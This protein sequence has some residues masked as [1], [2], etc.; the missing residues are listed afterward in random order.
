MNKNTPEMY[1][2]Q[3]N[4]LKALAHPTRL[5][6]INELANKELCVNEITTMV[7]VDA[8][9]ISNHLSLLKN[10]GIVQD[11]KKGKSVYY[12]LYSA[13]SNIKP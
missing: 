4:I 11:E 5:F 12:S 10:A 9:T 1:K 7:G 3:A 2:I 8:S 6:I 13:A